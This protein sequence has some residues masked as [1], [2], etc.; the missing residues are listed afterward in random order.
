[1]LQLTHTLKER[2]INKRCHFHS[3]CL[4]LIHVVYWMLTFEKLY[5]CKNHKQNMR[6]VGDIYIWLVCRVY[7][8]ELIP[9]FAGHIKDIASTGFDAYST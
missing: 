4:F 1:M 3:H 8:W 9:G 2:R 5:L 7:L 6:H